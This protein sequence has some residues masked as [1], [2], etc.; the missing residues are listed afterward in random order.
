MI[1]ELCA[2]LVE[3]EAALEAANEQ[4][5]HANMRLAEAWA[6]AGGSPE[7]SSIGE[8]VQTLR[9]AIEA[10]WHEINGGAP[11]GEP[12]A[13]A[14]AVGA[15]LDE[16]L[17]EERTERTDAADRLR[18]YLVSRGLPSDPVKLDDPHLDALAR[19]LL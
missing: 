15:Y 3:S 6:A 2:Q 18:A 19:A 17:G 1:D 14:E 9:D 12:D 16:Q 8:A 4:L 7:S 11:A 13:L 10:T 5:A